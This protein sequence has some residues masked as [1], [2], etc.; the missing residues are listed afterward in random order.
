MAEGRLFYARPEPLT[1]PPQAA[2]KL[3]RHRTESAILRSP[4]LLGV[5]FQEIGGRSPNESHGPTPGRG[6]SEGRG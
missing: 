4:G 6:T 2:V 1:C 5:L 3:K